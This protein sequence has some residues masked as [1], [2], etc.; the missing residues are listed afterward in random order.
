MPEGVVDEI[1]GYIWAEDKDGNVKDEP[2]QSCDDHGC[3][4]TRYAQITIHKTDFRSGK[5]K[6]EASDVFYGKAGAEMSEREFDQHVAD[7]DNE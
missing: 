5:P 4:T 6:P 2:D 3:D 7:Y 1:P